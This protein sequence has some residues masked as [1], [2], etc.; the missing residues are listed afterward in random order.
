MSLRYKGTK[1]KDIKYKLERY[2]GRTWHHS[3]LIK[4]VKRDMKTTGLLKNKTIL[5]ED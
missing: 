1:Y 3:F 5:K 4:L 2:T